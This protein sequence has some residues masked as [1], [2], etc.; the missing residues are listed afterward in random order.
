MK[1]RIGFS[2]ALIAVL[3][4]IWMLS[5]KPSCLTGYKASL[6]SFSTWRCVSQ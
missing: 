6:A 2:V 1:L 5:S 4:G 3:Y